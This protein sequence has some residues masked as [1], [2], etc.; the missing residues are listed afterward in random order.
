[1]GID[2]LTSS[3]IRGRHGDA[4]QI[5]R[6]R[7][8]RTNVRHAGGSPE[9]RV[10]LFLAEDLVAMI[11]AVEHLRDT[12]GVFR[13]DGKL[14]RANDLLDDLVEAR[15]FKDQRPEI[16]AASVAHEL[17]GS[18]RRQPVE[19]R[20]LIEAVPFMQFG[21]DVSGAYDSILEVR[22]ALALERQRL[23]DVERDD[24]RAR[25]LHHEVAN[26]SD[27]N[28]LGNP[29]V[30]RRVEL[31][32]SLCDFRFGPRHQRVHEVVG[33]HT[34]ALTTGDVHEP[35]L[36][37][38]RIRGEIAERPGCRIRQPDH[39][40]REVGRPLRLLHVPER[41]ERLFQKLLKIRLPDV[42]DV[43]SD[44][45]MAERGVRRV[46]LQFRRSTTTRCRSGVC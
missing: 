34:L 33:L 37:V 5:E 28:H 46:A 19:H 11:E 8:L 2:A 35:A 17:G 39:L 16:V 30:V 20:R 22:T 43:V 25:I 24:F 32:V 29:P 40:V 36:V 23:V 3:Y 9:P 38:R 41:P 26:G 27:R 21:Q 10:G 44:G 1:M 42:D 4:H 14:E 13:Q 15:C 45:R 18:R 7:Q 31:G 6:P 12:K